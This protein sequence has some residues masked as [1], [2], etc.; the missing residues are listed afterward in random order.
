MTTPV[1][2]L[3]GAVIEA[4]RPARYT[5]AM[6][7]F[8]VDFR[9][10]GT[11]QTQR[12]VVEALSEDAAF[13]R[14]CALRP[15]ATVEQIQELAPS[16]PPAPS[17]APGDPV[18]IVLAASPPAGPASTGRLISRASPLRW[19][20]A[21]LALVLLRLVFASASRPSATDSSPFRGYLP[22]GRPGPAE[23]TPFVAGGSVLLTL[24]A[25]VCLAIGF[26]LAAA[27]VGVP[28]AVGA[29][30]GLLPLVVAAT[31]FGISDPRDSFAERA[32]TAALFAGSFACL[33]FLA[34]IGLVC[35]RPKSRA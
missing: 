25:L 17:H 7:R 33:H 23:P 21:S 11:N 19:A 30:L 10:G 32:G 29:G 27:R 3:A 9:A 5:A 24:I 18:P 12:V 13:E 35:T 22:G 6:R 34:I 8:Q 15:G 4:D 26:T 2:G 14:V 1:A 31:A 16:D 28:R 20:A